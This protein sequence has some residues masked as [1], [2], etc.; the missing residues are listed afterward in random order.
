MLASCSPARA[1]SRSGDL[2]QP[3]PYVEVGQRVAGGGVALGVTPGQ[4][5]EQGG[6]P[7][8]IAVGETRAEPP[9]R[10]GVEQHRGAARA[11]G[12][13]PARATPRP[14]RSSRRYSTGSPTVPGRAHRAA[15]GDR[16]LRRASRRRSGTAAP[17][18]HR[19]STAA[20][21]AAA[22]SAS[23]KPRGRCTAAVTGQIPAE[24]GKNAAPSRVAP[25]RPTG[26]ATAVPRDW[27]DHQQRP[28]P[29]LVGQI[30]HGQLGDATHREPPCPMRP[31]PVEGHSARSSVASMIR[32]TAPR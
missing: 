27:S 17:G 26:C 5:L 18:P 7:I 30:G 10:R 24:H 15:A 21:T 20:R 23:V 29:R 32:S 28:V 13:S 8:R 14:A 31:E 19:R 11:D 12:L 1:R 4:V 16:P 22:R 2:G 6:R 9:V 25:R 3:G